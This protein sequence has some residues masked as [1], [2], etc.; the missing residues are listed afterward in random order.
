MKNEI[1]LV[2]RTYR[3]YFTVFQMGNP[4]AI[5]PYWHTPSLFVSPAGNYALTSV[6]DA[7]QFFERLIYAMRQNGYAR[8]VLTSVHVKQVADDL[9][10][11]HA[12][13]ERFTKEGDLLE[14]MSGVYTMRLTDET[15]RIASAVMIDPECE[16]QLA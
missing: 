14:K 13:G 2:E 15:W 7:E 4:R 3:A 12:R 8:S 16:L 1:E 11:V 6:K 9:A 10:L 5:T